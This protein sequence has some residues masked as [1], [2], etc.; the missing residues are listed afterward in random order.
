[1]RLTDNFNL[2]EFSCRDGS[3][4]PVGLMDNVRELAENLQV[5]REYLD[6]PIKVNSG[7]RSPEYNQRIKGAK[8]S[9]HLQARAADIV[10]NGYAPD[11]VAAA[12]EALILDGKMAK[13]G[14]GRY[15]NFTHYD[16]YYDGNRQRRWDNRTK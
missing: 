8:R 7:Y 12:I 11:E 5:L 6:A 13:G 9:Q 3:A 1:M 4:V 2:F 15:D 14:L 16:T 10:V